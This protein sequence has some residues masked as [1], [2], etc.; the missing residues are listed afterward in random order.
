MEQ[1][2]QLCSQ[3][4]FLQIVDILFPKASPQHIDTARDREI[5]VYD[6]SILK[7]T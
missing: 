7:M 4:L 2:R 3:L 1:E 6:N 5:D